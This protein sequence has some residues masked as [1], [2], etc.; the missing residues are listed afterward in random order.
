MASIKPIT[1]VNDAISVILLREYKFTSYGY[2]VY[3]RKNRVFFRPR[4][5]ARTLPCPKSPQ[6]R[7]S[8]QK[9]YLCENPAKRAGRI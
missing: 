6:Y 1:V 7:Q 2:R 8:K 9:L 4:S 5:E 3:R